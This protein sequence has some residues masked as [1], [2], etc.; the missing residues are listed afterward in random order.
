MLKLFMPYYSEIQLA[1]H[2][3]FALVGAFAGG[4]FMWLL[5]LAT[6]K[7]RLDFYRSYTCALFASSLLWII[8][9]SIWNT[10]VGW[11]LSSLAI[12]AA[13]LPA[14][15]FVSHMDWRSSAM[16]WFAYWLS[17]FILFTLAYARIN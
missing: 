10:P 1:G 11:E 16:L 7:R 8:P 12:M 15:K 13:F 6:H 14:V 2:M 3:A 4:T 9:A 17:Q 5:S